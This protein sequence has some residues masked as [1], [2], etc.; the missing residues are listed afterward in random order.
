MLKSKFRIVLL[1]IVFISPTLIASEFTN[2]FDIKI[3]ESKNNVLLS[4]GTL[5]ISDSEL[6]SLLSQA[7]DYVLF[8]IIN[9]SLVVL[10]GNRYPI[11]NPGNFPITDDMIFNV[12]KT[13]DVYNFL[14]QGTKTRSSTTTIELNQLGDIFSMNSNGNKM[15]TSLVCPPFCQ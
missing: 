12:F 8:K 13:S 5:S 1:F 14:D 11:Y 9:G 15:D 6:L 4:S 2:S 10:D 3:K 7:G